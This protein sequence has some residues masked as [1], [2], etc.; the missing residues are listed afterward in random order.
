MGMFENYAQV[1]HPTEGWDL[2]PMCTACKNT[3]WVVYPV[4]VTIG[5]DE[6]DECPN[7]CRQMDDNER[8]DYL[9]KRQGIPM[10]DIPKDLHSAYYASLKP[11]N[12]S[13]P[14][15][16]LAK[17][18]RTRSLIGW[19]YRQFEHP[20]GRITTDAVVMGLAL[21]LD[22]RVY[23]CTVPAYLVGQPVGVE[24]LVV[25]YEYLGSKLRVRFGAVEA[26]FFRFAYRCEDGYTT[27]ELL[28]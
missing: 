25:E 13:D 15:I 20:K 16:Y 1:S 2:E 17:G 14:L 10:A 23:P 24:P 9:I 4:N 6:Y 7:G 8:R 21:G 5:I 18:P 11:D 12:Y 3:G 27:Q 26:S 19:Q 28:S 22:S